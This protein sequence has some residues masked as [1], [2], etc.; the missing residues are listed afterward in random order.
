M[1]KEKINPTKNFKFNLAK[2]IPAINFYQATKN[3]IGNFEYPKKNKNLS[4]KIDE[5]LYGAR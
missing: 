2:E 3:Y 5:L 4:L 1:I